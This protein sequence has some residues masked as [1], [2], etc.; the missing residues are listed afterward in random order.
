MSVDVGNE[1]DAR[2]VVA[3]VTHKVDCI[4]EES[5]AMLPIIVLV[6]SR[7]RISESFIQ[8]VSTLHSMLLQNR[9]ESSVGNR[10]TLI[11]IIQHVR[12][13]LNKLSLLCYNQQ[14]QYLDATVID[15]SR[16]E[17]IVQSATCELDE[18]D[19]SNRDLRIEIT[20]LLRQIKDLEKEKKFLNIKLNSKEEI[21]VRVIYCKFSICVCY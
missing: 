8:E 9:T 10:D 1:L 20:E 4:V 16:M 2:S 13:I 3:A 5:L 7:M 21:L 12:R 18:L 17:S 11:S 6:C 15:N 14:Q 19:S